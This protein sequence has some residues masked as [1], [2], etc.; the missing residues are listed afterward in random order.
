MNPLLAIGKIVGRVRLS[1][2]G[3]GTGLGKKDSEITTR[4]VLFR[5]SMTD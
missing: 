5:E 2:L 3:W 1:G 4:V